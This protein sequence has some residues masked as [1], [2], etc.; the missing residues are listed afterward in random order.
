[1]ART[2][3]KRRPRRKTNGTRTRRA[4]KRTIQRRRARLDKLMQ[5][6]WV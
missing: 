6:K 2:K 4:K 3:S 5:W 1:M